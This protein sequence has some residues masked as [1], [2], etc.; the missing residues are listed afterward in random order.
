M[1]PRVDIEKLAHLAKLDLNE[2]ERAS[3]GQQVGEILTFIEQL[4]ELDTEG[5]EPMTSVLDLQNRFRDDL[6]AESL[7]P[8]VATA[9]APAASDGFFLVPAVLG[10]A[11]AGKD[12]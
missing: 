9:N 1:A 3:F 2:Q 7:D 8:A 10:T 12:S 4:S 6:P 5:I 11:A